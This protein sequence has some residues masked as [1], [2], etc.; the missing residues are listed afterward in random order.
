MNEDQ[1]MQLM[2]DFIQ[3][4]AWDFRKKYTEVVFEDGKIISARLKNDKN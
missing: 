1:R 4:S 3:M 2:L